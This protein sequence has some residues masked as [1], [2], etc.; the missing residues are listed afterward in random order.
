[1]TE[2]GISPLR[3]RMIDDMR[4]RGMGDTSDFSVGKLTKTK[5]THE[6]LRWL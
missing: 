5:P 1:M 2:E 4:I 3:Q 6:L